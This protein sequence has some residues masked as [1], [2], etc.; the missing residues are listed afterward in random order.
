MNC[1][2]DLGCSSVNPEAI[3]F[4]DELHRIIIEDVVSKGTDRNTMVLE[5]AQ[6]E[7]IE[8]SSKSFIFHSDCNTLVS[9]H[10]NKVNI[11]VSFVRQ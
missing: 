6:P 9:S 11:C 5:F 4:L 8:V 7:E 10:V 3:N 2:A 1:V